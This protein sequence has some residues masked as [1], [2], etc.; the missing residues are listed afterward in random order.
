M[1]FPILGTTEN[2]PWDVVAPHEKQAVK[3]HGQTLQ[4]LSERGGLDYTEVLA[5]LE[6]RDYARMEQRIA[7]EKVF[8]IVTEFTSL[9]YH[10]VGARKETFMI[11]KI[12]HKDRKI[13]K[14]NVEKAFQDHTHGMNNLYYETVNDEEGKGKF[15]SVDDLLCWEIK[16]N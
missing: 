3:N 5:V 4:Q 16:Q 13:D 8:Q 7:K 9:N 14:C 6:D 15:V 10:L 1:N 12:M 11:L 2:I